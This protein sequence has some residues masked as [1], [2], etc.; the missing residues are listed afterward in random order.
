VK[1]PGTDA[2]TISAVAIPLRKTAPRGRAQHTNFHV[3]TGALAPAGSAPFQLL[4][5]GDIHRDFHTKPEIDSLRGFPF[6]TESPKKVYGSI[7]RRR[8]LPRI[9][10]IMKLTS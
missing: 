8:D 2:S 3:E 1:S 9:S 7:F 4:A 10:S 6:H 5:V